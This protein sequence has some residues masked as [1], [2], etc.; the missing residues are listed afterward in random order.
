MVEDLWSAF[1]MVVTYGQVVRKMNFSRNCTLGLES[2][3]IFYNFNR[4]V[5]YCFIYA[6]M[7][8]QVFSI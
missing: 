5:N 2:Y 6:D 4:M 3:C 8:L 1:N 7:T